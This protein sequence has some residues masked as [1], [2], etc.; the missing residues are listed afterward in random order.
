[1]LLPLE[2]RAAQRHA[3]AER[4]AAPVRAGRLLRRACDRRRRAHPVLRRADRDGR[5]TAGGHAADARS[6]PPGRPAL[7]ARADPRACR[8][9]TPRRDRG[10]AR[11]RVRPDRRGA[12]VAAVELRPGAGLLRHVDARVRDRRRHPVPRDRGDDPGDVRRR[13]RRSPASP[14]HVRPHAAGD[15]TR[16]GRRRAGHVDRGGAGD[17]PARRAGVRARRSDPPDPGDRGGHRVHGGRAAAAALRHGPDAADGARARSRR[18][19][20][21]GVGPRV[22]PAVGCD[23]A[24]PSPSSSAT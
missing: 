2:R 5:R 19:R 15:D 18:D 6:P 11:D 4:G 1:M 17:R 14:V 13:P 3:R 20:R 16:R 12:D 24:R 21:G 8:D 7:D 10:R 22:H 9:R 23:R